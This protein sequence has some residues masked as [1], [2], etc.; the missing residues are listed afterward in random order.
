MRGANGT[1]RAAR[2]WG[3]AEAAE[4]LRRCAH[5]LAVSPRYLDYRVQLAYGERHGE[6]YR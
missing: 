1:Q 4:L 2:R 5:D 3:S 6:R